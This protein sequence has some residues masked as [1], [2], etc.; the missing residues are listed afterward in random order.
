MKSDIVTSNNEC[1]FSVYVAGK[2]K[3]DIQKLHSET[4]P[5]KPYLFSCFLLS[6]EI[7]PYTNYVVEPT[8]LTKA[9]HLV[10][11][12]DSPPFVMSE[13]VVFT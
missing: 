2:W 1:L 5:E 12:Q 9:T 3:H 10:D 7:F 8:P 6:R 4:N 13:T 11:V